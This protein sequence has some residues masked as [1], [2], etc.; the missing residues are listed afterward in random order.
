MHASGAVYLCNAF[1]ACSLGVSEDSH[2]TLTALSRQ[3]RKL[4]P[5]RR[6][7]V[8]Q[9]FVPCTCTFGR[10]ACKRCCSLHS[11]LLAIREGLQIDRHVM[12]RAAPLFWL[13]L[14]TYAR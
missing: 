2:A 14:A 9:G 10:S 11:Q 5:L 3:P 4:A 8:P 1:R 12:T 13:G 7:R 6:L